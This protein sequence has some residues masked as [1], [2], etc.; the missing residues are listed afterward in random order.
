MPGETFYVQPIKNNMYCWH[1][2]IKGEVGSDYEGGL[3]HGYFILPKD[4]PL[5][6]PSIYFLNKNGRFMINTSICLNI[7]AYHSYEWN[8]IWTL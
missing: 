8:P 6:P 4:Y 5:S 3:Y 1:F 7:T 2:T